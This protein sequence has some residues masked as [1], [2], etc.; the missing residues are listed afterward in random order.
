MGDELGGDD[1]EFTDRLARIHDAILARNDTEVGQISGASDWLLAERLRSASSVLRLIERVKR[2]HRRK[3]SPCHAGPSGESENDCKSVSHDVTNTNCEDENKNSDA[4]P[5][6][7]LER[8]ASLHDFPRWIGRFR[9]ERVL[10]HGGY[11]IVFLAYDPALR[12]PVALKIPRPEALI[13]AELRRRFLRE[14]E[15]AAAL[16]HANVVPVFESGHAGPVCYIAYA[17]CTGISLQQW[18]REQDEATSPNLAAHLLVVLSEAIQHA[19]SRGVVHRD[20]KPS[21]VLI[22]KSEVERTEVE[23]D[24]EVIAAS[25]RITDFGLAKIDSDDAD[26]TRTGLILGTPSYMSPEQA[27]GR[28]AVD[29]PGTDI[30]SLGAI[31]YELLTGVPPFGGGSVLETLQAVRQQN[32]VPPRRFRTEVPR[33]LESICLKCL[34]KRPGDRYSSATALAEDLQ[35]FLRGEPVRARHFTRVERFIRWCRKNPLAFGLVSVTSLFMVTVI[36]G[37]LQLRIQRDSALENLTRAK[38]AEAR[39]TESERSAQLQLFESLMAQVKVRRLSGSVGGRSETMRALAQASKSIVS[40]QLGHDMVDR[41]RDEAVACMGDL[42]SVEYV[43]WPPH[44]ENITGLAVSR[45]DAYMALG[46]QDGALS[47]HRLPD[48]EQT[49]H[50]LSHGS[51]IRG[52]SFDARGT[53]LASGDSSGV[54][55]TWDIDDSGHARP[56]SVFSAHPQIVSLAFSS[57]G[58]KLAAGCFDATSILNWNPRTGDRLKG[59]SGGGLQLGAI[60]LS[61]NGGLLAGRYYDNG[62]HGIAIWQTASR[63]LVRRLHSPVGE[64]NDVAFSPDASRLAFACDDGV[65]VLETADFQQRLLLAGEMSDSVTFSQDGQSMAIGCSRIGA[66]KIHDVKSGQELLALGNPEGHPN[67]VHVDF[68]SGGV[69][70]AAGKSVRIWDLSG[71]REKRVLPGHLGGVTSLEFIPNVGLL[72]SAS[73]DKT[74]K[75]W[76]PLSGELLTTM[77]GFR[78]PVQTVAVSPDAAWLATGDWSGEVKFWSLDNPRSPTLVKILQHNLGTRIWSVR[79]SPDGKHFGGSGHRMTVWRMT[80]NREG[81]LADRLQMEKLKRQ[82]EHPGITN[83]LFSPRNLTV[84]CVRG[85]RDIELWDLARSRTR[86]TLPTRLVG[87]ILSMAFTP[88]GELVFV[89][90]GGEVS[91]WDVSLGHAVKRFGN[92]KLQSANTQGVIALS[93][94]GNLLAI[95]DKRS[96]AVSIWEVASGKRLFALPED[97]GS[98]VWTLNWSP[99][100]QTLAVGRSDG[101]LLIWNIDQ[102]HDRLSELGVGWLGTSP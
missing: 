19:H 56:A 16:N 31:L 65:A 1:R 37:S 8:V 34:E 21:N 85:N 78:E 73:K 84:A 23:S 41:V 42:R 90:E 60:T 12:R 35:R 17:Y 25:L 6:D 38:E 49:D 99:I 50:C 79:F 3:V 22:D 33:D 82:P 29:L 59:F 58:E 10:G 94:D 77:G 102:I 2:E 75:L 87:N 20:L 68:W 91:V 86:G 28:K 43:D 93:S 67:S 63:Q 53:R 57:D 40:L 54:V 11:G 92:G 89:D 69:A 46:L 7:A 55:R 47:I 66:T 95:Q 13:T 80:V 14:A 62:E 9:V 97:R 76:D 36:L 51:S 39:S 96:A 71:S 48:G 45:T 100:S 74:V 26:H 72:V 81:P 44:K 88:D 4:D 15:A 64:V 98:S 32:P 83:L 52:L 18:L 27:D 61:P 5:R 70:S 24:A 101:R 30:Y